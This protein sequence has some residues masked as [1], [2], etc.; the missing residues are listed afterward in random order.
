MATVNKKWRLNLFVA[1]MEIAWKE[2]DQK[3]EFIAPDEGFYE[4]RSGSGRIFRSA[5]QEVR[6]TGVF[7]H[8]FPTAIRLVHG[9]VIVPRDFGRS[10]QLS[11][12]EGGESLSGGV[13]VVVGMISF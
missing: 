9:D 4:Q 12:Q 3:K 5:A 10:R 6:I 8:L 2:R 13:A 1:T 11:R 7:T